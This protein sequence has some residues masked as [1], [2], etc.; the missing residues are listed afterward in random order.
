MANKDTGK[1]ALNTLAQASPTFHLIIAAQKRGKIGFAVL[2][3]DSKVLC[4]RKDIRD[5]KVILKIT[6]PM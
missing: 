5:D 2:N 4:C 3:I 6:L 1:H